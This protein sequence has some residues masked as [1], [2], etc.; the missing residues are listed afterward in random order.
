VKKPFF[1]SRLLLIGAFFLVAGLVV[2]TLLFTGFKRGDA[3]NV[4]QRPAGFEFRNHHRID[5]QPTFTVEGELTNT[6]DIDWQDVELVASI[7]AGRAYMTYCR[8]S[9]DH[10]GK[11]STRNFRIVCRYTEG[12]DLPENISYELS[13]RRATRE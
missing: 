3:E 9:L 1:T 13:V 10:I 6:Q 4:V 12:H 5:D 7:Y 11:Q 8:N 2:A